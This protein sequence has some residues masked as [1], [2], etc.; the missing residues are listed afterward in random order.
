MRGTGVVVLLVSGALAWAGAAPSAP[1]A[2][3]Q[4][5]WAQPAAGTDF[6][7]TAVADDGTAAGTLTQKDGSRHVIFFDG[8]SQPTDVGPKI[9]PGSV[10]TS[11]NDRHQIVGYQSLN[12]AVTTGDLLNT[13]IDT[14]HKPHAFVYAGK[15]RILSQLSYAT[16]VDDAGVVVGNF[17]ASDQSLHAFAWLTGGLPWSPT[18]KNKFVDLGAGAANTVNNPSTGLTVQIGGAIGKFA[19]TYTLNVRTGKFT[20]KK[21]TFTG[22]ITSVN[23]AGSGGGYQISSSFNQLPVIANLRSGKMKALGL[24]QPFTDGSVNAVTEAGAAFGD[25]SGHAGNSQATR[26]VNGRPANLNGLFTKTQLRGGA[27]TGAADANTNGIFVGTGAVSGGV[28]T[29]V[30]YPAAAYEI[31][32]VLAWVSQTSPKVFARST[33]STLA[34]AKGG[35][36]TSA[37]NYVRQ[38]ARSN[39][40]DLRKAG[41]Y[42][43][44]ALVD[45]LD[46]IQYD[47]QCGGR[48]VPPHGMPFH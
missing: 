40:R 31:G 48:I 34:K 13:K 22:N 9:G 29:Y 30:A 8:T 14:A 33:R 47:L 37:C 16:D 42:V 44:N 43:R 17:L 7:F 23:T 1:A 25:L 12:P 38:A 4:I 32:Q 18:A 21:L 20:S 15:V 24:P 3:W 6:R 41:F 28:W 5:T 2:Q 39:Y 19:G 45:D 46:Q 11:M 10:A 26:W 27:L 35:D 36:Q